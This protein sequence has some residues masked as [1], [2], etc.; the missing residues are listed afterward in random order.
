M[1]AIAVLTG[2]AWVYLVLDARSMEQGSMASM[3]GM[4]TMAGT[5]MQEWTLVRFLASFTMWT[6]MMVGMM[7]PSVAP[8]VLLYTRVVRQRYPGNTRIP[9]QI[10]L[11]TLAYLVC[12]TVFSVIATVLQQ[13]LQASALLSPMLDSTDQSLGG[14]L[15][16]L[17]GF[18]Q[19]S[20]W[21]ESCLQLCR[22]PAEF[23]AR[24]FR[25]GAAGALVMG[26]RHG[27]YCIGCCWALMLLL[28]VGGVMNLWWVFLITL[29]VL[30]E[31][32]PATSTILKRLAT[33]LMLVYGAYLLIS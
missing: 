15:F 2:L 22:M 17:A 3:P 12:W 27:S 13:W 29:Y 11:F 5:S 14:T 10:T 31:K 25:P 23:I 30:L 33:L 1:A 4:A 7:M 6:I 32:L 19:L 18:Y 28:F 16:L 26:L 21:K 8:M 24:Y 9:L 20:P